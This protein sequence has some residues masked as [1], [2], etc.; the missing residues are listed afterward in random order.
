LEDLDVME[1][2]LFAD[3]RAEIPRKTELLDVE[4]REKSLPL[5]SGKERGIDAFGQ[6]KFFTPDS[7]WT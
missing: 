6:V 7:S 5:Y 1:I 3:V 4:S 2:W